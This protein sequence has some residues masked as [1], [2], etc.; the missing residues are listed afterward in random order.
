MPFNLTIKQVSGE[1][2]ALPAV[3]LSAGVGDI[4]SRIE[5]LKGWPAASQRLIYSGKI[6]ADD[7]T[8]QDYSVAETGFL[9]CMVSAPKKPAAPAAAASTTTTAAAPAVAPLPVMSTPAQA[10]KPA[11]VAPSAPAPAPAA[12]AATPSPAVKESDVALLREMGFDEQMARHALEMANGNTDRAAELLMSDSL[13]PVTQ[14]QQRSPAAAGAPSQPSQQQQQAPATSGGDV[15][16]PLRAHALFNE[17]KRTAQ[18]DPG[19][20]GRLIQTLNASDPHLVQLI[21]QNRDQFLR[22]MAE[23]VDEDDD[24][25][26]GDD[27][28]D[29]QIGNFI[30]AFQNA[31]PQQR[32]QMAQAMGVPLEQLP[33]I[34]QMMQQMPPEAL[35]Q[36]AQA[37]AGGGG[38]G[39]EGGHGHGGQFP[40]PN[41]VRL[42]AE[43]MAA[44]QRLEELGFSRQACVEAYLAC[45]KNE[46]LAANYLFSNPNND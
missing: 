25:L 30:Q 17:L 7:K 39:E 8:L 29:D 6:L 18:T 20:L 14:T 11:P 42:T 33:A 31:S 36:L 45:D 23:P 46:E 15:F 16:A 35:Q 28:G 27:E 5:K 24:V 21:N 32:Q 12:A 2:F 4:K 22:L 13:P 1:S 40:P 43:E 41:V 38:G 26:M 10:P 37:M 3:E 19:S 9:V 44:V 34:L